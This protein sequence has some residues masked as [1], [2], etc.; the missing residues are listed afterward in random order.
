[1]TILVDK[2]PAI[3]RHRHPLDNARTNNIRTRAID[4]IH[5]AN[6]RYYGAPKGMAPV[7]YYQWQYVLRLDPE[8]EVSR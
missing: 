8:A 7:G 6:S 3:E 4:A 2:R 5:A 1:M